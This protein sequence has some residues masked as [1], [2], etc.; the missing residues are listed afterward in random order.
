LPRPAMI[1]THFPRTRYAINRFSVSS[2]TAA[3]VPEICGFCDLKNTAGDGPNRKDR[4]AAQIR[5]TAIGFESFRDAGIPLSTVKSADNPP[6]AAPG[7]GLPPL[8]KR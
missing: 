2:E 5:I 3:S 4:M 6:I 1:K 8:S 7:P